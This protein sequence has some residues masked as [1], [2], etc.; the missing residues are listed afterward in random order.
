MDVAVLVDVIK[1]TKSNWRFIFESPLYDNLKFVP[2]QLVQLVAKPFAPSEGGESIQRNYSVASWP[3]SSNKF[4]LIVTYLPG[5]KMSEYLFK[6]CKIGDEFAY[7][8]PMG[9]FTLPENLEERDIYFVA[10][11]SGVSPFR[12]MLGYIANNKIPTKNVKLFFGTR[13]KED[14]PYLEEMKNFEKQIPN[15][16]YVPCLSREE[17]EG[18]NGYVHSA[19]IPLVKESK[20]KPL[21]YFCGWDRMIREGRGYLD[22]LGFEM[23]EDIRVEIFG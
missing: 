5:G 9:I 15:F 22:E 11:G 21:V 18:H 10:T 17:W 14:I 12:S 7:R 20:E 19:Y 4:E 23:Y 1:E 13:T 2:G 3:D 8:G 6:E 16:E